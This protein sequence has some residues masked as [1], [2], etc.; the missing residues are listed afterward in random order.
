MVDLTLCSCGSGLRRLRCCALDFSTLSPHE[1][2]APLAP[3]LARAEAALAAGDGTDAERRVLHLLELAP[4]H[5]AGLMFLYRL[6]R[7]VN[8]LRPAEAVVGRVV[9]LNP[10]N[11]PAT[12]ELSLLLLGRGAVVEAETHAR[13]AVRIAPLAPQAHNLMGMAMT[14]ANRLG[15]GEYHYRRVLAL[16]GDDP[17]VLANLAINL[18]NQGRAAEARALFEKS[19]ALRADFLPAL[20]GW[21]KLEEA[22]RKFERALELLDRARAVTPEAASVPLAR[23][24]VLSRLKRI[25]EALVLLDDE[26]LR[27]RLGPVEISA[28]GRLL[29]RLGRHDEAFAAFALGKSRAIELG[30]RRY[31]AD[32]AADLAGR[33]KGFFQPERLATLPKASL[34]RD[35]PQPI[36]ILGFPRS[37]TTLMEQSLSMHTRV[38]AGD[39]LPIIADVAQIMPRLFGSPLSYPEA[40]SELWMGD[41]RDGL[42]VLRDHYLSRAEQIGLFAS[43]VD[44]FTDKMPLNEMHLGLISLM[45]PAS[46]LI[47]MVRHPLDVVLSVFSNHLTHGY[48]CAAELGT[49]ARH[50]VLTADLVEH[51]LTA[52]TPRYLRMRYED[53]VTDHEASLREIACFIGIDFDPAMLFFERNQRHARTASYAQVTEGLYDRSRFR[54]RWYRAQLEPVV[55]ILAPVIARLGYAL[56]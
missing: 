47:H 48:H 28:K 7:A 10:N 24:T 39:E 51:Y 36:F 34:R 29:D 44:F 22:D 53:L 20:L 32:V 35:R 41:R 3:M 23:A 14:E 33:L 18:G 9:A 40:L 27:D 8:R 30:A 54:Y 1:A 38:A 17:V 6:H 49:I 42:D 56:D 37:G 11:F 31:S 45:F 4:G 50:Y 25:D 5:E 21:A 15:I 43:C 13:N 52:M 55:E 46:P 19:V 12:I 2:L 16:A 26:Q